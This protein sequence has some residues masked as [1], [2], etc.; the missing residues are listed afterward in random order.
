MKAKGDY[1]QQNLRSLEHLGRRK[2]LQNPWLLVAA[3]NTSRWMQALTERGLS[4]TDMAKEFFTLARGDVALPPGVM[5][6]LVDLAAKLMTSNLLSEVCKVELVAEVARCRYGEPPLSTQSKMLPEPLCPEMH[7]DAKIVWRQIAAI[8]RRAS[9]A[10]YPLLENLKEV[11]RRITEE[12]EAVRSARQLEE[13]LANEAK[14]KVHVS[15]GLMAAAE[16][17]DPDPAPMLSLIH[18]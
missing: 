8:V 9:T 17:D 7:E 13:D 4:S 12:E 3:A 18:I 10:A 1:I 16:T 5:K 15:G 11:V 14:V 2:A 6:A